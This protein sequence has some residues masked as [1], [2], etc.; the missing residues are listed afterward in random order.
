MLIN[1]K[2]II[3]DKN[4]GAHIDFLISKLTIL[5]LLKLKKL[6]PRNNKN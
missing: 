1:L 3:Y 4:I 2:T 6:L 5:F